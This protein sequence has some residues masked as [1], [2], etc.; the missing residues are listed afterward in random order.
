[1]LFVSA[2]IDKDTLYLTVHFRSVSYLGSCSFYRQAVLK[3]HDIESL[4]EA[5]VV[6]KASSQR[7]CCQF[8]LKH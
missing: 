7:Y 4:K 2:D 3:K 6:C 5:L 1:M 8:L